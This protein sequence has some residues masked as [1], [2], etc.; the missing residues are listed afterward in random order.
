[1]KTL[2]LLLLAVVGIGAC[3]NMKEKSTATSNE[4]VSI[5]HGISYG[6]CRGYCTTELV[7][8]PNLAQF[9]RSSRDAINYPEDKK[10][11]PVLPENWKNINASFDQEKWNAMDS[12]IGCPDCADGGAEYLIITTKSGSKKVTIEAGS[13]FPGLEDMVKII[14]TLRS[15]FPTE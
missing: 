12:I 13:E 6:H 10:Y 1:M 2:I 7:L 15:E 3:A 8:E 14:R 5:T 9:T 11:R 4:I